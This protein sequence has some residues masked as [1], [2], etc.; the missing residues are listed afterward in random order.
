MRPQCRPLAA[1]TPCSSL[2]RTPLRLASADAPPDA[3]R[4]ALTRVAAAAAGAHRLEDVLEL[5]AEEARR[6]V[7]SA[8]L[9]VSRWDRERDALHT[10]INVGELGP[11]EER[12]PEDELYP[13]AEQP[14][15]EA[16]APAG[17]ALLQR[18][19]RPECRPGRGGPAALAGQGVRRSRADHRERADMGRGLDRHLAG[20]AALPGRR[21]PLSE[22]HRHTAR[23][24]AGAGGAVLARVPAG[25]RGLADRASPTGGRCSRAWSGPPP[26]QPRSRAT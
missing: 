23:P 18:R 14:A 11:G 15:G 22:R 10:L 24:G 26:A 5:V 17:A 21:R 19:R 2:R 3:E 1:L 13:L 16:H 25:L 12:Y 7:G 8:S 9:S 20:R 4:E 6:A